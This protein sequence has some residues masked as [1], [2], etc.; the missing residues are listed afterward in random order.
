MYLYYPISNQKSNRES[1]LSTSYTN[2]V[3]GTLE[4]YKKVRSYLKENGF[5][6][7]LQRREEEMNQLILEKV[8]KKSLQ[9]KK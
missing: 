7:E 4:Q 2:R 6:S 9:K 3:N 5:T 8:E 1:Y